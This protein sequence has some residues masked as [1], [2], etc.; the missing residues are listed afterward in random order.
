VAEW[1]KAAVLKVGRARRVH[2]TSSA[3]LSTNPALSAPA[4]VV[5]FRPVTSRAA[6]F[7]PKLR[8]KKTRAARAIR[9]LAIIRHATANALRSPPV[10]PTAAS[11]RFA[12]NLE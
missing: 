4:N 8:P 7:R 10:S 5:R 1:L 2:F 3:D 6:L 12:A 11:D 9:D